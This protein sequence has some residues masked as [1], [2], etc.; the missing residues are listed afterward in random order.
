MKPYVD[1]HMEK[2]PI[3]SLSESVYDWKRP[4][5]DRT[6]MKSA[7]FINKLLQRKAEYRLGSYGFMD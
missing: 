7:D 2:L 6:R 4:Y 5:S 1:W 3:S